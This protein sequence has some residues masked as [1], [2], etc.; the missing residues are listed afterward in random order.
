MIIDETMGLGTASKSARLAG[1]SQT[2]RRGD[3]RNQY[4]ISVDSDIN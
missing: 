3:A 4:T 1:R 2:A